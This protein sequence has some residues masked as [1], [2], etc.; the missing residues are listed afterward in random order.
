MKDVVRHAKEKGFKILI[1]G[2]MNAHNGNW[3][4]VRIRM[5][6]FKECGG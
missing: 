1:D 3:I 5:E 4:N 2:D 6:N